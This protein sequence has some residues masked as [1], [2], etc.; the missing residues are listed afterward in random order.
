MTFFENIKSLLAQLGL[1]QFLTFWAHTVMICS[2]VGVASLTNLIVRRYIL[3]SLSYFVRRTKNKWDDVLLDKQVFEHASHLAAALVLF[4]AADLYQNPLLIN[5]IQRL[6]LVYLTLTGARTVFAFIDSVGAIYASYEVS[7]SRPIKG[8]LQAMKVFLIL[9][10]VVLVVSLLTNRSPLI[11]FSG[12]GAITAILLLVFRDPILG[13]VAGIQLAGNNMVREGD[14]IQVP[15]A[16][17]D[18]DVIDVSLTTV[19]VQNWDK[20]ITSVPIYSLVSA[21][22]TNWRGMFESGGRRIKRS[23]AIDMRTVC[24]AED[25]LLASLA[26]VSLITE[27]VSNAREKIQQWRQVHPLAP[28]S[29]NQPRPTNIGLFRAY[30]SAYLREHNQ[31]SDELTFIVRQLQPGPTGMPLEVYLFCKDQRWT[32]YEAVQADIFEHLLASLPLFDLCIFQ[33]PTGHD[34]Q[35]LAKVLLARDQA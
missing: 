25:A 5:W 31:V 7:R 34:V 30:V 16:G 26:D 10:I 11:L 28:S 24:F 6:A 13:I 14:W 19:K 27:K 9:M 22:F 12:L 17:A 32:F 35:G 18:G 29:A 4:L 3:H 21:A 15:G 1:E 8:Y 33:N 20:T 2:I 23:L